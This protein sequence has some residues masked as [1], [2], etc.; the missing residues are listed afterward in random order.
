MA[1]TYPL[2][3]YTFTCL[4]FSRVTRA[5][6]FRLW[7]TS[8]EDEELAMEGA[9]ATI[10]WLHSLDADDESDDSGYEAGDE[11]EDDGD[12]LGGNDLGGHD[13]VGGESNNVSEVL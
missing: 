11:D 7:A 1:D 3:A 4:R 9:R 5:L 6:D 8:R 12:D 13:F 10:E 2:A